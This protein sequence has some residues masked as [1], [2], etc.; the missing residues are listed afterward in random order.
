M[1][2]FGARKRD[3]RIRILPESARLA[4]ECE[5]AGFVRT[6][7]KGQYFKA[8]PEID[9]FDNSSVCRE[10][11]HPQDHLAAYTKVSIGVNTRFGPALKVMATKMHG[12]YGMRSKLTPCKEMGRSHW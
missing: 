6:V 12:M 3:E 10:H 4:T 8:G 1:G 9:W 2:H 7:S 5:D 11:T